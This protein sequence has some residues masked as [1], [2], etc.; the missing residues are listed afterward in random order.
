MNDLNNNV[1]KI[2]K[3]K[4]EEI[5]KNENL[6]KNLNKNIELCNEKK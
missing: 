4:N 5:E 6:E 3:E 1:Q 2:I